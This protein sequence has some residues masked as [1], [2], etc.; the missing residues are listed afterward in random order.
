MKIL[1][2][3]TKELIIKSK[4]CDPFRSM[5]SCPIALAIE[6]LLPE[7]LVSNY[8]I[9]GNYKIQL[10]TIAIKFIKN[11]DQA[12]PEERLKLEPIE[13]EIDLPEE[14]INEIGIS[15]V[16]EVLSTSKTLEMI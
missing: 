10:P 13:F 5:F 3:V 1:I 14:L 8:V 15:E 6:K 7:S 2:K 9:F 16:E 4:Y 12:S 11:F